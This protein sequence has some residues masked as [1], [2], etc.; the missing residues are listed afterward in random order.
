MK[1]TALKTFR[2]GPQTFRRGQAVEMS[3]AQA[4]PLLAKKFVEEVRTS[5]STK[6]ADR[7]PLDHDGDGRKGGSLPKA[8]RETK[9]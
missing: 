2:H 9:D 1:L 7:D 3:D 4:K 5:K 8:Q 6:N